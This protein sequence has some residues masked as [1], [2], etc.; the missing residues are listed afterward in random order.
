MA[1][2]LFPLRS[3]GVLVVLLTVAACGGGDQAADSTA[4]GA[5]GTQAPTDTADGPAV[6]TGTVTFDGVPPAPRPLPMD[7]DPQ[8]K[9]EPGAMSEVLVVGPDN[10]LKNVFVYV[11]D[12]LGDRR[13]ATPTE[14]VHLD[15]QG[16]RYIPHVFGVQV[17]QPVLIAN[18]DA[19]LHNVN[20]NPKENRAFNFG[21]V[22][23]TPAVTRVFANPEIGVPFRCDVHPWMNAYAGVVPHPFFAVTKEDGTFEIKGLPAGT[24]TIELWH[25]Q[26]GT[27]T[28]PVT[29]DGQTPGNISASFKRTT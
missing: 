18:S 1:T 3:V 13:Y 25:E 21:Q 22:P 14:P 9:P 29:V 11:K 8:C 27:Q 7:S 10:G 6:I 28:Q 19:T 24:Y 17:G 26:L 23:R 12:G 4:P 16:C 5:G 15:Q 20:A 2:R